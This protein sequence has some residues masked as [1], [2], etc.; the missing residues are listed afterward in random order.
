MDTVE[1]AA[2]IRKSFSIA[3]EL[4][5]QVCIIIPMVLPFFLVFHYY[6]GSGIW[7]TLLA[8]IIISLPSIAIYYILIDPYL[9]SKLTLTCHKCRTSAPIFRKWRCPTCNT[10]W[11]ARS[12]SDNCYLET[13]PRC[14]Q[15]PAAVICTYCDEPLPLIEAA[16]TW[17]RPLLLRNAARIVLPKSEPKP[18]PGAKLAAELFA[19][20]PTLPLPHITDT[21]L[22]AAQPLWKDEGEH[23]TLANNA[24]KKSIG[25][26]LKWLPSITDA[27][28]TIPFYATVRPP[29]KNQEPRII[30]EIIAPFYEQEITDAG[31]LFDLRL[32]LSNNRYYAYNTKEPLSLRDQY[33]MYFQHTSLAPLLDVPVP[34][35]LPENI[36]FEHHHVMARTGHGK[37][38]AL[39]YLIAQDLEAV[40]RGE[41]S[42]V[43]LDSQRQMIDKI[44]RLKVFAPGQPLHGRLVII[45]PED[46][47]YPVHLPLFQT[48]PDADPSEAERLHNSAIAQLQYIFDVLL[49]ADVSNYQSILLGQVIRLCMVIPD[50][51]IHT[52]RDVLESAAPF[53]PYIA[54]LSDDAQHFFGTQYDD[55]KG[56]FVKSRTQMVQKLYGIL[57]NPTFTRMFASPRT[58]FDMYEEMNAGKVIL[59]DAAQGHL[60]GLYKTF[61]RF[62]IAQVRYAVQQRA[63]GKK[64]PTYFYIDEAHEYL[65]SKVSEMLQQARKA[66]VGL[67]LAHQELGDLGDLRGQVLTN[68]SIK[69]VGGASHADATA[70]AKEMNT[71][72]EFIREQPNLTFAAQVQ[73]Q[74]TVP[75]SIPYGTIENMEKMTDEEWQQVRDDIRQRYSFKPQPPKPDD[76]GGDLHNVDLDPV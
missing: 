60:P 72:A 54:Q 75:L 67:I 45:D 50:A 16:R 68:T 9:K 65:D 11:T 26:Y 57:E 2:E 10:V 33:R 53:K 25:I 47:Q 27:T 22:A 28:A 58:A 5:K 66:N 70:L 32:T 24:I 30:G 15:L 3:Q 4:T 29:K 18:D 49:E 35:A 46:I 55:N 73:R 37:T 20:Q 59:I 36:R 8:T 6:A 7:Q 52:L 51:T 48:K 43:V 44:K 40:A 69:F 1:Q 61:G 76:P 41:A 62:F 13:C 63:R 42:I 64:L 17:D 74:H 21:I 14:K 19:D 12:Q 56:Q 31:L 39:Q 23:A 34:Y 71:T 38:Q